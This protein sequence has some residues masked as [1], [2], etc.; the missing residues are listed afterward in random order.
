MKVLKWRNVFAQYNR[1]RFIADETQLGDRNEQ[2]W[3]V[4]QCGVG[5]FSCDV[6]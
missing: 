1:D 5:L 6:G 2:D 3:D 4:D